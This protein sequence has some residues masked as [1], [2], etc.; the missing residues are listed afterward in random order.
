MVH[1]L[2]LS[3]CVYRQLR[4]YWKNYRFTDYIFP[5]QKNNRPIST[6][7]AG[8]IYKKAKLRAKIQKAGGPHALR[9][10]FATHMLESGVDVFTIK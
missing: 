8:K 10:A 3:P 2:I 4:K 5:G 7:T 6:S 1:Y 9:H